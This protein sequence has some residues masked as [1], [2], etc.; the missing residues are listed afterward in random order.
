MSVEFK[1][2]V[3]GQSESGKTSIINRFANDVFLDGTYI[4]SLGPDY[5]VGTVK[6]DNHTVTF[7]LYDTKELDSFRVFSEMRYTDNICVIIV[8]DICNKKSYRYAVQTVYDFFKHSL[9]K[10]VVPVLV[11]AKYDMSDNRCV[12]LNEAVQF[13]A[14]SGVVFGGEVSAKTGF[15]VDKLFMMIS[16]VMLPD[17]EQQ[18]VET[19]S[20]SSSSSSSSSGSPIDDKV[21]KKSLWEYFFQTKI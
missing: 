9:K 18:P 17:P 12:T 1:C 8:Y 10:N 21:N 20:S 13:A 14:K 11:G 19:A 2:Q 15:N 16:H 3:L 7:K 6:L 5:S 4:P